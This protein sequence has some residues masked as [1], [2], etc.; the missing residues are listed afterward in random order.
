VVVDGDNRCKVPV[1]VQE[2]AGV[3]RLLMRLSEL[4]KGGSRGG[5]GELVDSRLALQVDDEEVRI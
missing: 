5:W 2:G 1:D 3:L 4:S